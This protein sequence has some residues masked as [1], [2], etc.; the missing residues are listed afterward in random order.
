MKVMTMVNLTTAAANELKWHIRF[1]DLAKHIAQWS[2]DPKTKVGAV[3][4]DEDN[5]IL[6]I[7]YNGFPRGVQ[8]Y[9]ERYND[10]DT[11]LKYVV[12]AELNAILNTN[13]S[14]KDATIYVWAPG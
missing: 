10:R 6:G 14:V 4:V 3:I 11:K 13:R 7:G 2:K 1:L 9:S 12:H 8:D 5:I